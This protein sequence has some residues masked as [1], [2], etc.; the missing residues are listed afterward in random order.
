MA[1]IGD[2]F[3]ECTGRGDPDPPEREDGLCYPEIC[4]CTI[5]VRQNEDIISL[6]NR[7]EVDFRVRE[8]IRDTLKRVLNLP[9]TTKLEYKTNND[10]MQD[11]SS[12]RI[13]NSHDRPPNP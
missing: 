2:Q 9:P 1:V 13:T 12:F 5:S 4:G 7:F 6:W 11:K 10:S 3:D 8:K